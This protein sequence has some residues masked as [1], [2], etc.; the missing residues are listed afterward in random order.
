MGAPR[1]VGHRLADAVPEPVE[2]LG[3]AAEQVRLPGA[4]DLGHGLHAARHLALA[5]HELG[6]PRLDLTAL[7]GPARRTSPGDQ[8]D[9][10]EHG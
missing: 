4:E 9:D 5:A 2:A 8:E 3:Q 6:H 7:F 10:Q 1:R